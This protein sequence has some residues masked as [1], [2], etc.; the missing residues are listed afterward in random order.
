MTVISARELW[1]CAN[2]V[3]AQHGAQVD[4]VIAERISALSAAGDEAGVNA[5]RAIA[6]RVDQLRTRTNRNV[7]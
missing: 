1:A 3:V 6:A 2:T 4:K 5:W 7:H